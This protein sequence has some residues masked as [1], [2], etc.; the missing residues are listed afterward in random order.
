M[1]VEAFERKPGLRVPESCMLGVPQ[2]IFTL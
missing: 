1:I 2:F